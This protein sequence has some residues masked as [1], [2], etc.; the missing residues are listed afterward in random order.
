MRQLEIFWRVLNQ[1]VSPL[2]I[3]LLLHF[4]LLLVVLLAGVRYFH[5]D[6]VQRSSQVIRAHAVNYEKVLKKAEEKKVAA[7]REAEKKVREKERK[8]EQKLKREKEK[9]LEQQ[10]LKKKKAAA[11]KAREK[12]KREAERKKKAEE[13]KAKQKRAKEKK[14][15]EKKAKEKKAREERLKQQKLK[16][17]RELEKKEKE[18]R[19]QQKLREEMLLEADMESEQ[20]VNSRKQSGAS[21]QKLAQLSATIRQQ[22]ERVWNRPIS[23][24]DGRSCKVRVVVVPGGNVGSVAVVTSSGNEAF[25]LSVVQAVNRAAPFPVPESA[26]LRRELKE[27]EMTFV[28]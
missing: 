20:I 28:K 26:A 6:S 13:E 27:L 11:K 14:A 1:K 10:R 8:R 19:R 17:R 18:R 16:K 25:D 12:K 5:D 3:S 7:K 22:I 4:L 15:K 2:G 9:K 21:P 24:P 23:S